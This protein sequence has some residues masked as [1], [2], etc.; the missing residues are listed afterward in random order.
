MKRYIRLA[1]AREIWNAVSKAFYDGAD[2]LQVFVLNQ[3][4][5][6]AKQNGRTLSTY[7]GEL[8]E[9]FGELDHRDKVI[10]ES[11]K[12]VESYR[13]SVQRQRV[14][15]FLAGLD[16]EFEQV[17]GEILRK[18]PVPELEP[19]YALVR[20]ESVRRSKMNEELET[21]ASAMVIRNRSSSSNH[22][23]S[24]NNAHK[25]I[26]R[27]THCNRTGHVKERCFEIV[28]YPEWWDHNRDAQKKNGIAG[29]T[30]TVAAMATT[31]TT[32]GHS[33]AEN[34]WLWC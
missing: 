9:I 15:I 28:G 23:V 19:C 5:F 27:C 11:E 16:G 22:K 34:D 29:Y 30:S 6:S 25:S 2:E 3:R 8:V 4:A 10:M 26:S 20:R 17:R 32:T 24:N 13:K 7:Y 33:N 1:T 21:E 14:H 31:D 18:E 12:D